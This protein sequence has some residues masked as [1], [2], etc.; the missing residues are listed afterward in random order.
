[1]IKT[2]IILL[3]TG[4][5]TFAQYPFKNVRATAFGAA[6]DNVTDDLAAINAAIAASTNSTCFFPQ[7]T[8][9]VSGDLTIP[10]GQTFY[11]DSG[12]M[13]RMANGKTLTVNGTIAGDMGQ[14]FYGQDKT[15]NGTITFKASS[16]NRDIPVTWF[17]VD[18]DNSTGTDQAAAIMR[19][20]NSVTTGTGQEL[21]FPGGSYTVKSQ[22]SIPA[23]NRIKLKGDGF[24]KTL[25]YYT[26]PNVGTNY[27]I[28]LP[29][30]IDRFSMEGIGMSAITNSPSGSIRRS[31][32]VQIETNN[33][34]E[35]YMTDVN[36]SGFNLAGFKMSTDLAGLGIYFYFDRCRFD[37]IANSTANGGDNAD[38]AYAVLGGRFNVLVF[39]ECRFS[40]CDG[41]LKGGIYSP[42][43]RSAGVNGLHFGLGTAVE[44]CGSTARTT[45]GNIIDL[46]NGSAVFDSAWFELNATTAS[47]YVVYLRSM[48]STRIS[49]CL[50]GCESSGNTTTTNFVRYTD[51]CIGSEFSGNTI[52][53]STGVQWVT[54]DSSCENVD[55]PNCA[56]YN[57]ATVRLVTLA[58]IQ[59]HITSDKCDLNMPDGRDINTSTAFSYYGAGDSSVHNRMRLVA[60]A[61]S[62]P[63]AGWG[64]SLSFWG[65]KAAGG[66]GPTVP[67]EQ[68][69]IV[70]KWSNA[71]SGVEQGGIDFNLSLAGTMTHVAGLDS[72]GKFDC[73][74]LVVK[75]RTITSNTTLT[76]ADGNCYLNA[77]NLTVTLPNA[78]TEPDRIR[79]I[80]QINP[81]SATVASDSIDGASTYTLSAQYKYL[82]VQSVGNVW[83]II[84]NN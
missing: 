22:I 43:A 59:S 35:I 72:N 84:A 76:A 26:P 41:V 38:Y 29:G 75:S 74:G 47:T 69:N 60:R 12:A 23:V 48:D 13:I 24:S 32:A 57:N 19:A 61:S 71:T 5:T 78:G 36:F 51:T 53:G 46:Y 8:Y 56:F 40:Y 33:T 83:R 21:Y 73:T 55:M 62:N 39:N 28:S 81:G 80:K 1:M 9:Y 44:R 64:S 37:L 66:S 82:T 3:L 70:G 63:S 4:L 52:S 77:T 14:H 65:S 27:L 10:K 7:C 79:T 30:G 34:T 15:T 58:D 54:V 18:N 68:A 50:I 42:T 45:N 11:F 20:L 67:L 25:I 16:L 17:G 2:L 49:N 31:V 6:G